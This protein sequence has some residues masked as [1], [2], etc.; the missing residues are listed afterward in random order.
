M[1]YF[2]RKNW[3]KIKSSKTELKSSDEGQRKLKATTALSQR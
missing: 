1:F 3:E 2:A